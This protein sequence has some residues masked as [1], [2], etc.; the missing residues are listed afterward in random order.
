MEHEI[1]IR[2]MISLWVDMRFE[3]CGSVAYDDAG[4]KQGAVSW[5]DD[6]CL[7]DFLVHDLV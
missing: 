7:S 1:C 4:R 5:Q 2:F 3:T 6:Y